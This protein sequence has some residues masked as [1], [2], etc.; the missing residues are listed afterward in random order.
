MNT[1]IR[2][3]RLKRRDFLK[4]TGGALLYA[5]GAWRLGAAPAPPYRVGIGHDSDPYGATL[6]AIEATTDWIPALVAGRRVIIKPNLVIGIAPDTGTVTDPE[7]VRAVVDLALQGGANEVL[8][9]EAGTQQ[10]NFKACGYDFF[11]NYDPSGRVR[12][13][14]L[15]Q[16]PVV[17]ANVPDG[18]AYRQ[19]FLPAM[20]FEPDSILVSVAK[21]KVHDL[22]QA[23]L[24]VKNL[25]GLPPQTHYLAPG[26]TTGRYAMHDRGVN[27][28]VVDIN[29]A[30]PIDFAV[31]DGIWGMERAGPYGGDPVRLDIVVAGQNPLAV[32]MVCLAAMRLPGSQ[33]P[34]LQY[35]SSLGLGPTQR[36]DI[37]MRGDNFVPTHTFLTPPT[38]LRVS[39][40][41]AF[42][43]LFTPRLGESTS[44]EFSLAEQGLVKSEIVLTSETDSAIILVRLLRDWTA[45][46]AGPDALT[47]DGRDDNGALVSPGRYG[48]RI[49]SKSYVAQPLL[50]TIGWVRVS[51]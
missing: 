13:V 19:M 38:L 20:L 22:T 25:F 45:R 24:S 8:I 29:L 34:H 50:Y 51:A 6:R 2:K 27:E 44:L 28:A 5:G 46:P 4:L 41:R 1:A 35:A 39:Y 12:L 33:V 10:A 16:Q 31:V 23:T 21:L 30:R 37:E 36:S 7:V 15:A 26:R 47:W 42:P 17:L 40:P 43:P 49:T 48:V 11:T 18:L 14:D 3:I 9:V 32:D